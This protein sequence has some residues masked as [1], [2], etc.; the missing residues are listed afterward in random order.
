MMMRYSSLPVVTD[1]NR[2]ETFSALF[3]YFQ[4][5]I[6]FFPSLSNPFQ[7]FFIDTMNSLTNQKREKQI[8]I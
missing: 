2:T 3:D 4:F 8:N 1:R 7:Q 5:Q 6:L